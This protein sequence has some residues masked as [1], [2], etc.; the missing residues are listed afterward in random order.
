MSRI[1]PND[2]SVFLAIAH[3]RSIRKAADM[4]GVT[5][6]A[7]SHSLRGIEERL[8]VRLFNRTTRSVAPTEAG[9]RLFDRIAPAFRDIEDA[10]EDLNTFRDT[11]TG[12]LRI[13]AG[14]SSAETVLIDVVARFLTAYPNVSVEIVVEN[15]LVDMVSQGFD[16]GVRFGEVLAQDM[17]AVPLGPPQ[18]N[19]YVASPAFFRRYSMPTHPEQLKELPCIRFRFQSGR[20]YAWEFERDGAEL[21]VEVEGPLTVGEQDLGI[22]AALRGTGIAFAFEDQV[23]DLLAEGKLVRVLEDWCPYYKGYHLYYPSRRQL[24]ATL[25]AFVD[26]V[27]STGK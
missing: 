23:G 13:N 22:R 5:P 8:G 4:L 10:L 21:A 25:R 24:P 18:R 6:S 7:L 14:R 19:A 12:S 15:A 16:A 2:L 26:F 11:P 3:H 20:Y 27:R 17:I 1:E 9:E